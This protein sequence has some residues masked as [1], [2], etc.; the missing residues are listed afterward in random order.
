MLQTP[1]NPDPW[2]KAVEAVRRREHHDVRRQLLS[3]VEAH[4]RRGQRQ[5]TPAVHGGRMAEVARWESESGTP[6]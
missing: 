6:S 2:R 3:E 5:T 4:R 1:P